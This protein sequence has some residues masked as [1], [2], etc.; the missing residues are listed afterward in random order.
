MPNV[1]DRPKKVA[2]GLENIESGD[3]AEIISDDER[4]LKLAP[5]MIDRIG[6]AD[7]VRSWKGDGGFYH[8]LVRKK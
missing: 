3:Y 5:K 8:V 2:S 1:A 4:M 7:L 6:K